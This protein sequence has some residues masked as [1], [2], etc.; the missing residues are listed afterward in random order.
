MDDES[1]ENVRHR[2]PC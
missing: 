1:Q 2:A